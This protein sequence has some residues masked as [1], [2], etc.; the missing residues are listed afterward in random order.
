MT[1][2]VGLDYQCLSEERTNRVDMDASLLLCM[3]EKR[4]DISSLQTIKKSTFLLM[5]HILFPT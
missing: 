1:G 2:D 5:D 4:E 3:T